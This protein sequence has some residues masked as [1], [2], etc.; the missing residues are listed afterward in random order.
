[1]EKKHTIRIISLFT[2]F[3]FLTLL[4][5]EFI[6]KKEFNEMAFIFIASSICFASIN[7]DKSQKESL[8]M[9][10]KLVKILKPVSIFLII[11]GIIAF[12]MVT[13]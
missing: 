13:L 12:V 5:V 4:V 3:A 7:S 9:N 2:A 11:T 1:M 10:P 6:T 8:K